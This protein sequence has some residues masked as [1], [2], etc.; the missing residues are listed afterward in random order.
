MGPHI[1]GDF[2]LFFFCLIII[3]A[4]SIFLVVVLTHPVYYIIIKHE[5]LI[6]KNQKLFIFINMYNKRKLRNTHINLSW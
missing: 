2:F 1:F 4:P 3:W 5:F 6:D